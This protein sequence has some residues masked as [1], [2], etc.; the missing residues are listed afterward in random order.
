MAASSPRG[1]KPFDSFDQ[2]VASWTRTHV[3][4][5]EAAS[6]EVPIVLFISADLLGQG[7]QSI[8]KSSGKLLM[9][10]CVFSLSGCAQTKQISQFV[11]A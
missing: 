5:T 9:H 6:L 10:C 4:V 8:T 2:R 1:V 3:S 11:D 7:R